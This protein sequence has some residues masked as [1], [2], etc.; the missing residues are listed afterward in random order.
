[1]VSKL[2][3]SSTLSMKV[4][5]IG[6]ITSLTVMFC[7]STSRIKAAVTNKVV[8]KQVAHMYFFETHGGQNTEEHSTKEKQHIQ[9]THLVGKCSRHCS[10][11][12]LVEYIFL[13]VDLQ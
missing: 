2:S 12:F 5:S 3:L 13:D 7:T 10:G 11:C 4:R 9:T 1:M 8:E 6:V